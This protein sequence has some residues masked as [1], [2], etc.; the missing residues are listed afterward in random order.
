M[1]KIAVITLHFVRNYGSVLQTY[2]TQYIFEKLG[3]DVE[4][5]DYTRPNARSEATGKKGSN[6]LKR[7]VYTGWKAVEN[8]FRNR[9]CVDFLEKYV[10][11][12][13]KYE[14]NQELTA[15]PPKADIYITGSDQTWNSE[16]N[17]GVLPEYYLDFAPEGCK[18]IGCSVSIGMDSFPDEEKN[19]VKAYVEK[20]NAI[21]VRERQ[22]K[23]ILENLGYPYVEH[24]I[25]P[26]LALNWDDWKPL[27][28]K[29]RIK[30]K[31]ILIYKLNKNPA[32]EA[33][34]RMLAE[35][36]GCK[37][38]RATYWLSNLFHGGK[39]VFC[40]EVGEFLSLI[41]NAEYVLTDSFHC[42]AFSLNFHK[43]FFVF[44]P[45][46]YS[47][48]LQSI[49]E[50]TGTEHRV[51]KETSDCPNEIDFFHVDEVFLRERTRIA[52]FIK[53]NC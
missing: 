32:L 4:I 30:T 38:V 33:Y 23:Y 41:D 45:G 21:S 15:D 36:T 34:A 14:N 5:I 29:N 17:G 9:V 44:Y 22:A 20:Y 6:I 26:T 18:R 42:T 11:L 1:K 48:R 49:L 52:E 28:A 47:S 37:I 39:C 31:Y 12:T 24:V 16:Y 2:A 8:Y 40:P 13:R 35:K 10:H 53:A 50:L 25:D 27:I 7:A 19:Q 51:I 43:K 3:Y 46:K